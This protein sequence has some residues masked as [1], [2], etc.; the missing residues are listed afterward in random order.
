M[1]CN[2]QSLLAG[3]NFSLALLL[4]TITNVAAIFTVP[5]MLVW[6]TELSSGVNVA[7]FGILMLVFFLGSVLPAIVSISYSRNGFSSQVCWVRQAKNAPNRFNSCAIV[8]ASNPRSRFKFSLHHSVFHMTSLQH[9]WC[10]KKNETPATLVSQTSHVGVELFS[11]VNTLFCSKIFTW[12]LT[13]EWE[14][15]IKIYCS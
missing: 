12:L 6:M 7:R 15:S 3:G 4:M 1:S 2:F 5:P 13:R 9:C 11:Y 14:R 10:P 8:L